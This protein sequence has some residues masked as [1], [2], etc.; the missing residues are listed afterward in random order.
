MADWRV[1]LVCVLL[2]AVVG[3]GEG[4]GTPDDVVGET[5]D[6]LLD[7][8][9]ADVARDGDTET[10]VAPDVAD[11]AAVD[12]D[13]DEDPS[14]EADA[15]ADAGD[16]GDTGPVEP[17]LFD[18]AVIGD[19]A[20]A[21]C[22][23]SDHRTVFAELTL[24]EVWSLAYNSIEVVDGVERTIRMRG[25]A[26]KPNGATGLPGVVLA[27]GLGGNAD[28]GSA[29]TLAA[30]LG[31]FVIAYTGPGGGTAPENTS[32]GLPATFDEGRRMFDTLPDRRGSWFW[33]HAVAAMRAVTCLETHPDV[34]AARLGITGFS[35]GGVVSLIAAGVDSRLLASVPLSGTLRWDVAVESPTAWQHNLLAE[36]GYTTATEEWV[37]LM[38]WLDADELLGT[39]TVPVLMVDG[40]C[41]EF[42]PLTAFLS[43]YRA[44]AAA[45]H[46]M[47]LAANFDHGCYSVSG[48]E[49]A[50]A[51]EDR[52]NV[53]AHGGQRAWF[54]HF[55]G[56][57]DRYACMPATPT[58][59]LTP[60]GGTTI[61]AV[62]ADA[63]CPRLQVEEVHAWFSADSALTFFALD[64]ASYGGGL[65]GALAPFAM[66]AT[67]IAYGDVQYRT[68]D[69]LLPERFA[70][71]TEPVLPAGLVPAIRAFG[72]CLPP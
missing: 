57:D 5:E 60:S 21:D 49:G 1:F 40:T 70:L 36:A 16:D 2:A 28:E 7:T 11:D 66:T 15:E 34:D 19:A 50:A 33:A 22:V 26:A 47:S 31:T 24:L 14:A 17:P 25:F 63:S 67:A 62:A 54:R 72:T 20:A 45:E 64:L 32:E 37:R 46:R 18:M 56:M 39:T 41:D 9:D 4:G 12:E 65:Y 53:H 48:I 30:Q 38:E 61:V 29:T 8:G 13:A 43:T 3:C 51:I 44:L 42:F 6:G 27:H 59:S 35:A 10:D 68:D 23:F 52:A 71:S 55:F 69:L 58:L